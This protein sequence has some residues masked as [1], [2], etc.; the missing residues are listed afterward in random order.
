MTLLESVLWPFTLAY[1]AVTHLRTRAYRTGL[2]RPKRLDG[3]VIS[4]GNLTVGGTGKTPMVLW[5]AER[6][7]ADG[8]R[9]GILTRGYRGETSTEGSTSDEVRLLRARLGDRVAFGVGADRWARGRELAAQGVEWFILDDGFQHIQLA[10]DVDIVLID[11]TNPF[12]GGHLLPAG[13]LREPKSALGRADI[14][15]ITRTEH[16]PAVEAVIRHE[17][18]AQIFYA[19]TQLDFIRSF[20]DG[21]MGGRVEPSQLGTLFAF[22]GIANPSAYLADLRKWGVQIA[23]YRSFP[24]HHKYT[25]ND[26]DALASEA[27]AAGASGV[28][29]T[30]K[31]LPNLHGIQYR[32]P[33]FY[34][35]IS[36]SVDRESEFWR[37][38]LATARSSVHAAQGSLFSNT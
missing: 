24:D 33:T 21:Q 8:K 28:I 32:L 31:D 27:R 18:D 7:I 6:L 29:C 13:R 30:E 1:G 26:D 16:S 38:V 15:V 36:M 22:C 20:S 37:T 23:G 4:V 11:A 19:R 5:V 9:T 35:S 12:G 14:I 17:S 2:L 10:R 3:V 34:C 25:Q